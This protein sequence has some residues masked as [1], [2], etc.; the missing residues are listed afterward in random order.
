MNYEIMMNGIVKIRRNGTRDRCN[1][2]N[3]KY[4][5]KQLQRKMDCTIFAS[6]VILPPCNPNVRKIAMCK[7]I[8]Y[9][10]KKVLTLR[11]K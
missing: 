7:S 9:F 10:F 4:Q 2:N 6:T 8:S 5:I 11:Q 3:G 1:F